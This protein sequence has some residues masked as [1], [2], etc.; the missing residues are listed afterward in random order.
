FFFFQ[1]EDGIRDFHVTGV[2]TCALP[3]FGDHRPVGLRGDLARVRGRAHRRCAMNRLAPA[4]LA[5]ATMLAACSGEQP[6]LQYG[7]DPELP[8]PRRGLMPDMVIAKPAG[9]GDR[10]PLVPEGFEVRAIATDLLIPRQTLV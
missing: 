6:P 10:V 2:Q 8:E 9:W 7:A 3:I 4:A 1:A 5:L